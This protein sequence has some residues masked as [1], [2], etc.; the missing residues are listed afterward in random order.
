MN[1]DESAEQHLKTFLSSHPDDLYASKRMVDL[2]LKAG[3]AEAALKLLDALMASHPADLDLLTL[4]GE[5][6]LR[7]R[8]YN[9]AAQLFE[10]ASLLQPKVAQLHAELALSR[11]GNG[12]NARAIAELERAVQLDRGSERHGV[13]LV[14][15]HLRANATDQALAA[16]TEMERRADNPLVQN[17]KG[18]VYLA[19]R[20]GAAARRSFERALVLDPLYLPALANLAQLDRAT[21]NADGAVRRYQA[22][23]RLA[24]DNV[25]L[26]QALAGLETG[27]GR[28]QQAIGWLER[29]RQAQPGQVPLALH[30]AEAYTRTGQAAKAL[31]L[32]RQLA[33]IHPGEAEV[34]RALADLQWQAG[35]LDGA[36]DNYGKLTVLLPSAPLPHLRLAAVALAR[37]NAGAARE[38]LKKALAVAPDAFDVQLALCNVLVAQRQYGEALALARSVQ[39]RQPHSPNGFKLE[40]DVHTAQGRHALALPAYER[41]FALGP[42][43]AALLQLHATLLALDQPAAADRQMQAWLRQHP[44]DVPTRVYYASSRMVANDLPGAIVQFETVL[45][46]DPDNVV[47]LN[48]AAWAHQRLGQK[49]ALG[50]AQRAFRLAPAN[51]GVMDTLGWIYLQNGE[52][53]RALPLLQKAAALAPHEADI[54]SH[55]AAV[56]GQP[57]KQSSQAGSG[58]AR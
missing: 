43:S 37:G 51:P 47:A 6:R 42:S 36:L 16:V 55:L 14:M 50:Y 44:D 23:L 40:A 54:Q 29:A 9:G 11:L 20:D 25:D 46:A 53:A 2:H 27:R 31:L 39:Q 8:D 57:V 5:A 19:A 15:A 18:G 24:P 22:A 33:A 26:L 32:M 28:H 38:S 4:A 49:Q 58:P 21:G 1:A 45:K 56:L 7:A 48:D 30:L 3:R 13:L 17:L 35:E 12:E 34:L 52:P 10:R 41:A